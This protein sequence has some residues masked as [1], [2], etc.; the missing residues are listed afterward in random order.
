MTREMVRGIRRVE[1]GFIAEVHRSWHAYEEV[2]CPTLA[3]VLCLVI[4]QAGED[5]PT[6]DR[7]RKLVRDALEKKPDEWPRRICHGDGCTSAANYGPNGEAVACWVHA[8][9]WP[10]VTG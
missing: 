2:I 1:G 3:D 4:G 6:T 8:G 7:L 10:M 5:I 9:D